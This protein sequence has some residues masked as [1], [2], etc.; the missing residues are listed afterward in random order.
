MN[1][2]KFRRK[3]HRFS[4]IALSLLMIAS[5]RNLLLAW[6]EGGHHLIAVMAFRQLTPE[7]QQTLMEILKSHPQFT[8]EFTLPDGLSGRND[9]NEFLFGRAGYWPDVARR[10]KEYDRPTWHYQL[11]ATT[12]IGDAI[13]PQDPVE[14]PP[15]ATSESQELHILQA[16]SLNRQILSSKEKLAD[17]KARALCWLLHLLADIHQPCHAGSLYV[18]GVF[19]EGDRG[20]NS[21]ST[22][23]SRNLHALW[24]QLLG[25]SFDRSD[26]NRRIFSIE[27]DKEY[28]ERLSAL[29]AESDFDSP[30]K[31]VEESRLLSRQFVYTK[32]VVEY[33]TQPVGESKKAPIELKE[34]YLKNAGGVAQSQAIIAAKRLAKLLDECLETE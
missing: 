14:L 10:Y 12:I 3:I 13:A 31:W 11:G 26:V 32:E 34:E 18:E 1:F 25:R 9:V 20:A 22:V 17:E 8:T 4:I 19:P 15:D 33:A 16:I 7:K 21:I 23:Q 5:D 6:S 30:I 28:Q 2:M 29:M 27:S 24:D